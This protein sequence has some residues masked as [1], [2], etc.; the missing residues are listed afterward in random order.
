MVVSTQDANQRPLAFDV[1]PNPASE[2][3]WVNVE[4]PENSTLRV[5]LWD[6]SGRMV[7]EDYLAAGADRLRLRTNTFAAGMY[8][9][10]VEGA[11]GVGVKKL[12]LR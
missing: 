7:L 8:V 3:V 4:R 11:S 6:I 2:E 9:V 5:S 1:Y 10:R 12:V